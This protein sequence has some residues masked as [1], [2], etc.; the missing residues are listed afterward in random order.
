[1]LLYISIPRY[2]VYLF[3]IICLQHANC[4]AQAASCKHIESMFF[5][6]KEQN[7]M[8][9]LSEFKNRL[10]SANHNSIKLKSDL[11]CELFHPNFHHNVLYV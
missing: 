6:V 1:M 3:I 7:K 11:K 2:F 4:C 5:S 9:D 10:L 8:N